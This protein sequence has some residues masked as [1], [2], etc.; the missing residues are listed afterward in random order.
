VS[1]C[2]DGPAGTEGVGICK[3]GQSTCGADGVPGPCIGQVTPKIE[4]CATEDDDNC[5]GNTLVCAG[6][7]EVCDTSSGQ[8]VDPCDPTILAASYIGCVYYP[9][10]TPNQT[11]A[12][13]KFT[14]AVSNTNTTPTSITVTRGG[15]PVS[16]V[17]VEPGSVQ[18]INLPWIPEL[19]GPESM[20]PVS[21][22][23]SILLG[24]GAYKLVSNRPV[25][26]Y[27]YSP[28]EYTNGSGFS[29]TNDASLLTP[30]N[31]WRQSYLVA[32]R[33][34]FF[35][36]S[37]FY[38]VVASQDNTTVTLKKGARPVS[39][40]PGVAGVNAS[41]NGT[42]VMNEGDVLTVVTNDG[43]TGAANDLSGT[44]VDADKPV[45]VFGGH[46]C[47]N[48]PD[49][50]PACDHLEES[51]FPVDA[52]AFSYLVAAPLIPNGNVP[53]ANMVR[54]VAVENDTDLVYDPPQPGA[55]AAIAQA[56]DWV[57]FQTA[58]S[59]QVSSKK[60]FL[61]VQYMLGQEAGGGSG[62]P[63]MALAVPTA[64][65]RR[66]YLFHAP[67]NYE[68]NF[69]T[70]T[71]PTDVPVLLDGA[72]VAGFAPIG[73]TG[74]SVARVQLPSVNNGNHTVSSASPV[75]ITVYGYGQ[76]TSYWYP[77]GL[78]L[79]V[80]KELTA[81]SLARPRS[82]GPPGRRAAPAGRRR[83]WS[84]GGQGAGAG[85][86]RRGAPPEGSS[87]E[88]GGRGGVAEAGGRG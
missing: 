43:A 22:A 8:C 79:K 6:E 77:G 66:D 27:Q 72:A 56:G 50:I 24:D 55:P 28:L 35:S 17:T 23:G 44:V 36:M 54:M 61:T 34:H 47:T 3:K 41:N 83:G 88:R 20:G 7:N 58:E 29:F 69:V 26:V 39:V 73:A 67:I 11:S 45:Q 31:A 13:F 2:Y 30:V 76:Y 84:R 57:E 42:V 4:S 5:D 53:K 85:A 40:K 64:Q 19:K 65:Y 38:T 87:R 81:R 82:A 12:V 80:I 74:F 51:M 1:A 70:I 9:T 32:A 75:G 15:N 52:L 63:A 25:T 78:D 21:F 68:K 14:L 33:G 18:L 86:S 60:R 59:F 37:A 49:N 46:Q 16:S 10:I 62:D 48:V 71:A